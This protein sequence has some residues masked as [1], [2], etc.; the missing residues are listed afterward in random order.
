MNPCIRKEQR[1]LFDDSAVHSRAEPVR[2]IP[3][4]NAAGH[5]MV[6]GIYGTRCDG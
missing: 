1:P 2:G 4:L 5:E 3:V 6:T